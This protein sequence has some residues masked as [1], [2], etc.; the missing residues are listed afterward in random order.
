MR[1]SR[2]SFVF[3]LQTYLAETPEQARKA[4][5]PSYISVGMACEC[6]VLIAATVSRA[7]QSIGLALVVVC[8][9]GQTAQGVEQRTR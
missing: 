5:T 6:A 3:A 4:S 7:D 2:A 9:P 1:V 8:S